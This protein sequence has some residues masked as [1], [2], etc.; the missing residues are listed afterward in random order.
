MGRKANPV[1]I[2]A[3]VVGAI[4]L[5]VMGII[6]FGSGRLFADTTS[7]VSYFTGSVDGLSVGSPVKFKGVEIGEVT[8]IQLDLGEE[9]RIPVWIEIDNKKIV[10]YGAGRWTSDPTHLRAEVERGLRA[11]LNT[12]S[13]VTGLL[14]V[15]L[16]YHPGA[17]AVFVS[18]P[19]D[20]GHEIPTIP[21]T[22]EQAQQ[23]AAEIIANL[24][25][26][27]FEGFGRAVRAA[28]DGINQ[29]VNAPGLQ[30]ALQSLPETVA[31]VNKT[32]ESIQ[33]LAGNL[34]QRTE[35][36]VDEPESGLRA[37]DGRRRAGAAHHAE[38]RTPH[39]SRLAACRSARLG[40]RRAPRHR[41]LDPPA[42]GLPRAQSGRAGARP[43]GNPMKIAVR[44]L[45]ALALLAAGCTF[46]SPQR[47]VSRFYTLA[48]RDGTTG[49]AGSGRTPG[50]TVVLGPVT[51]PAY[52]DRNEVAIRVSPTELKYSPTER[53][54]APLADGFTRVLTEDLA[55][56]YPEA[57][58][59]PS[60]A[61]LGA[62]PDF[63]VE[64][65]V[66]RFEAGADGG[67]QLTARWA[68]RDAAR[69]VLRIRQ[70][71]HARQA[72]AATTEGGVNALEHRGWRSGR[73]DRHHV[74]RDRKQS[75]RTIGRC[76]SQ[77]GKSERVGPLAQRLS[78][79]AT[80]RAT[81]VA[82]ADSAV[83]VRGRELEIALPGRELRLAPLRVAE[84]QAL[85]DEAEVAM[86]E[87]WRVRMG[88]RGVFERD[89]RGFQ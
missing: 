42:R 46:L 50:P 17:P 70:S 21:T 29:T 83:V 65:I 78:R 14:F 51:L 75:M 47:D 48:S 53:W 23:A 64:V 44:T 36:L 31:N 72:T 74:A 10:A 8:S 56:A 22:L 38:R 37:L 35:P 9:A 27:D 71:Q 32:L 82:I 26:V 11:Q 1:V 60:A 61:S 15:Q 79:S 39:R 43:R 62:T 5:A 57:R 52:L 67:A 6:V 77:D 20:Q 49:T 12:Q 89:A 54:A 55:S 2:G 4:A 87:P 28:I 86:D 63:S 33:R 68:V 16:D 73:R 85:V 19:D 40:P 30:A 69:K 25:E 24:K 84:R 7:F 58:V 41:P 45:A 3:F 13:I 34:D 18:P 88:L 59:L 66:I 81:V 80:R 76:L